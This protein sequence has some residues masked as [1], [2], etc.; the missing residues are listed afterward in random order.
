MHYSEYLSTL[1]FYFYTNYR[2]INNALWKVIYFS[3]NF[4]WKLNKKHSFHNNCRNKRIIK[5]VDFVVVFTQNIHI[6][7]ILHP[8]PQAEKASKIHISEKNGH[9]R[10]VSSASQLLYVVKSA[11]VLSD[12]LREWWNKPLHRRRHCNW[13]DDEMAYWT[14]GHFE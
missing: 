3:S 10:N 5:F 14:A 7:T 6:L 8:S 13:T 1:I 9:H 2:Y 11:I 12:S 4:Y